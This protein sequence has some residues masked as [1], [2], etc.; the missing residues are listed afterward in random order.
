MSTN[1]IASDHRSANPKSDL[2][3]VNNVN[4]S[5]L[6]PKYNCNTG[7][8]NV[9]TMY[10]I[11]KTAQIVNEMGNYQ[12]DI[13]GI[14]ECRWTGSG[15]MNTKNDK[16]ESYT[17]IHSG[18]KDTHHRGVA[19]INDNGEKFVNFC[20]NHNC[21]ICGTIFQHKEIHKLT[22]KSPDGLTVNQID[23][24]VIN[25]KWRRSLKDVHTC[26]GADAGS[27]HYLVVSRIKLCLRKVPIKHDRQMRYNIARLKH[28]DTQKAFVLEVKNQFQKLSTD[29]LDYP[30][31]EERWNQ[32]K[33]TYCTA[34]ESALGYLKSTDKT[35]LT[36]ETW[37]RIEER[38]T[39]K[40]KILN[41]KSKRI[42]ER[43]QKEYNSKDNE[44]KRSARQHKRAYVDKL[45]EK[46]ETAA[47]KGELS[48][49][50][51]ITKQLYRHTKIAASIVKDKDGNALTTKQMQAKR[52]AEHFTEVLNT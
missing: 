38:K 26:R 40:S 42:Q 39:I 24:V 50:Y 41:T 32:I 4:S 46:W 29:E 7:T 43:L 51:R 52:W 3:N 13:L 48:T 28:E 47:Q 6:N 44:I 25:N 15:K 10:S 35:W 14:S 23:H 33:A 49:V 5:L 31:V 36:R 34:A 18:Q 27:D 1:V 17:I 19:L 11:S 16:G 9:Q 21:V 37:R 8:W 22:W 45:A 2:R 30:S 12:L 20:L